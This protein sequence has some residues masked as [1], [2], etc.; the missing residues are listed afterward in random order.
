MARAR[1]WWKAKCG[2][3]AQ[4]NYQ[5]EPSPRSTLLPTTS[6]PVR[7]TALHRNKASNCN[8]GQCGAAML[9][10]VPVFYQVFTYISCH[11]EF[12]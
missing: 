1:P 12:S 2:H 7:S 9:M 3:P 6:N 11:D 10:T 5:I 4:A 8:C